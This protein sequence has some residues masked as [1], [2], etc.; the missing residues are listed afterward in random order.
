MDLY[1]RRKEEHVYLYLMCGVHDTGTQFTKYLKLSKYM[2]DTQLFCLI[3]FLIY[4]LP[5][6]RLPVTGFVHKLLVGIYR[7]L[8]VAVLFY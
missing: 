6:K 7:N 8:L 2:H 5:D 1:L 3:I 4:R